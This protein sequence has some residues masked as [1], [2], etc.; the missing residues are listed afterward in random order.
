MNWLLLGLLVFFAAHSTSIFRESWRDGMVARLGEGGWKGLYS[1]VSLAGLGL[2]IFGY[3]LARQEPTVLY[4]PPL[5]LRHFSMLLMAPVVVL[6][7]A[8]YFPGRIQAVTKHPLLT[9]TKL[10]A[11]A[12]LLANG[13]AADV[14]VFGSFLV[15][16][17][18]DRI[19]M[20]HRDQRPL[21]G[22]PAGRYN[23]MIAVVFGLGVYFAF[24]FGVH[25]W[26]IGVPL[27]R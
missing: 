1:L 4:T 5:W 18:V 14:L 19:S 26:L 20:K 7:A 27:L 13:G 21:P 11:F 12:H 15:W 10:W 2:M 3:G 8:P 22:A 9:A 25:S 16:A 17:V 23:D 24:L 6:F